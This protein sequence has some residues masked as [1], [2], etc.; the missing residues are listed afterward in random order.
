[1]FSEDISIGVTN[2]V[3]AEIDGEKIYGV[4]QIWKI[5]FL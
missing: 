1:M 5:L 2:D 3:N 4:A